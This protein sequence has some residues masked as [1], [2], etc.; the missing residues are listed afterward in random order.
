MNHKSISEL[1][2][3]NTCYCQEAYMKYQDSNMRK[4]NKQSS[5][6]WGCGAQIPAIILSYI[7]VKLNNLPVFTGHYYKM[8]E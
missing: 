2:Q 3:W 4:D 8:R 5:M 1:T 7:G 6:A